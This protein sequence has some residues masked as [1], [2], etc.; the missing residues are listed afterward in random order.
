ML[1]GSSDE[2]IVSVSEDGILTA[3]K[4]GE[5]SIT[6]TSKIGDGQEVRPSAKPGDGLMAEPSA[7]PS[8]GQT[9][10]PKTSSASKPKPKSKY[11][12]AATVRKVQKKLNR[13][14]YKCSKADGSFGTKTKSAETAIYKIGAGN[15]RRKRSLF[16]WQDFGT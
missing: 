5:V 15:G 2:E 11:Y 8:D 12:S 7:K 1:Y 14:G 3:K 6:V 10:K 13:L 9:A 4:G 16:L